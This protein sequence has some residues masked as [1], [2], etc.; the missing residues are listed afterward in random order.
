MLRSRKDPCPHFVGRSALQQGQSSDVDE[1]V[2]G[3]ED[4]EAD[5]SRRHARPD[6][7]HRQRHAPEQHAEAEH[8]PQAAT[9]DQRQQDEDPEEGANAD[10]RVEE[11]HAGRS[12]TE[13]LECR[14]DEQD[15]HDPGG[16][17]L[18][19]V[20][21]DHEP[22]PALGKDR[23]ESREGFSDDAV[24]LDAGVAAAVGANSAEDQRRPEEQSRRQ[25]EDCADAGKGQ[26]HAAERGTGEEADAFERGRG[27]IRGRQLLG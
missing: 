15:S 6:T 1:C 2:P 20:E 27:R 4:A 14:H 16:E 12:Q 18:R 5:D 9:S 8:G 10:G 22:E 24:H 23:P 25:R 13:D 26:K 21:A 17:R 7:E 3:A 11:A 19:S